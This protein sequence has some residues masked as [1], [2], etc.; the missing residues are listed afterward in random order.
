MA[1][2]ERLGRSRRV[3]CAIR[4]YLRTPLPLPRGD[5][6]ASPL[7]GV[8]G[9]RQ[10]R[11]ASLRDGLTVTFG[12]TRPRVAGF[13]SYREMTAPWIRPARGKAQGHAPALLGQSR[14]R[15]NLSH[16]DRKSVV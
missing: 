2:R 15:L 14:C 1:Q 8:G 12:R 9:T 4:Y 3:K 7:P 10:G 6:P 5:G 16:P 11:F 13:G